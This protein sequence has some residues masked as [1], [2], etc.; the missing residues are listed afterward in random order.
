MT[1]CEDYITAILSTSNQDICFI[2]FLHMSIVS[3][4]FYLLLFFLVAGLLYKIFDL[5]K[6]T[7]VYID[8][9]SRVK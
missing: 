2:P 7:E 4:P 3:F 1:F 6:K 9:K 5:M 8:F